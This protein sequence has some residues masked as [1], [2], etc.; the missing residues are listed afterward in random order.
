MGFFK[1]IFEKIKK[2][3]DNRKMKKRLKDMK[4]KSFGKR[5]PFV[6]K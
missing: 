5:D 1:K 2:F 4:K 3:R 6:Y